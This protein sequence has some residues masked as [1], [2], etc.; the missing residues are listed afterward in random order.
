[1]ERLIV[2][3]RNTAAPGLPE[4]QMDGSRAV[5]SYAQIWRSTPQAK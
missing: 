1:M 4:C 2:E 5:I 3:L